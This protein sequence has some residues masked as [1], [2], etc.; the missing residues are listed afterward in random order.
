MIWHRS[1][2]N[3]GP[4]LISRLARYTQ[5]AVIRAGETMDIGSATPAGS[6]IEAFV[7]DTYAIL[8][9]FDQQVDLRLCLG[10]TKDELGFQREYGSDRLLELLKSQGVYPFTHLVRQSIQLP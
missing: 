9:L 1:D 10:I 7:F 2:D 3:W 4:N 5:Q 8:E 6:T